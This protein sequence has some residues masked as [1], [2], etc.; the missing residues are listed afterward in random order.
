MSELSESAAVVWAV[1]ASESE[2]GRVRVKVASIEAATELDF[3]SVMS[4]LEELADAD[5]IARP[6]AKGLYSTSATL[7]VSAAIALK[8]KLI[9]PAGRGPKWVDEN[10]NDR[11]DRIRPPRHQVDITDHLIREGRVISQEMDPAD[12]VIAA[13]TSAEWLAAKRTLIPYPVVILVGCRAWVRA[14]IEADQRAR[15]CPVCSMQ[16]LKPGFN[17]LRHDRY[18]RDGQI[19]R[20][21]I[22]EAAEEAKT[23][24]EKEEAAA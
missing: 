18:S 3:E 6:S 22:A 17:C 14:E 9:W 1:V 20:I 2:A 24:A 10:A 8:L 7:S 13:E 12:A 16:R 5:L 4:A 11:P 23:T 19:A 21:L 15:V